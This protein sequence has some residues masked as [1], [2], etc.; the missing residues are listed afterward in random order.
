MTWTCFIY[1]IKSLWASVQSSSIWCESFSWSEFCC[2]NCDA[3]PPHPL[4]QS[5]SVCCLQIKTQSQL[6]RSLSASQTAAALIIQH[7]LTAGCCRRE[8]EQ[9]ELK[10]SV[11]SSSLLCCNFRSSR[12]A[13]GIFS[14]RKSVW[15]LRLIFV[16]ELLHLSDVCE[17]EEPG[18]EEVTFCHELQ[19]AGLD[20]SVW[21]LDL[22]E[23]EKS[24]LLLKHHEHEDV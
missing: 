17:E 21:A 1:E 12:Q 6:C 8:A 10:T 9:E 5:S 16:E 20:V 22:S 14:K 23:N 11:S 13:R 15:W 2:S 4:R 3:L 7:L 24:T 19:F 18:N